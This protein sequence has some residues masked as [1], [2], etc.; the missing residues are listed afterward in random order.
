MIMTVTSSLPPGK[1]LVRGGAQDLH[2]RGFGRGLDALFVDEDVKGPDPGSDERSNFDDL[3]PLCKGRPMRIDVNLA[4][5]RRVFIG[6]A[7]RALPQRRHWYD[8]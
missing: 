5:H 2:I 6:R 4:T 1:R 8:Q 7:N 3:P